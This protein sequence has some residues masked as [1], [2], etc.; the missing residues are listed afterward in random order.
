MQLNELI[1]WN[2]R[3]LQTPIESEKFFGAP[4]FVYLELVKTSGDWFKAALKG[5]KAHAFTKENRVRHLASY[6]RASHQHN[7]NRQS[8]FA[9]I[10][11]LIR[12]WRRRK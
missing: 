1:D 8:F 5:K 9:E 6:I 2:G 4:T 3:L 12:I 11:S 7:Q 10:S